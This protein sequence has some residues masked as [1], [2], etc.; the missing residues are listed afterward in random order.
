MRCVKIN[1]PGHGESSLAIVKWIPFVSGFKGAV[2]G[3]IKAAQG[4]PVKPGYFT[5]K[6]KMRGGGGYGQKACQGME[7]S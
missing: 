2:F 7:I 3:R 4:F 6:P 1:K 5:L